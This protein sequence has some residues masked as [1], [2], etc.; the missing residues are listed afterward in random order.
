M[1]QKNQVLLAFSGG[2]DTTYCLVYLQ[3][4]GYQVTTATI[5]TGGFSAEELGDIEQKAKDLGA[6]KHVTIDG[7]PTIWEDAAYIIKGEYL[8]GGSYPSV[9]APERNAIVPE[10]VRLAEEEGIT[11]F[12]HGATGAGGD[13]VRFDVGL[14]ALLPEAK[15]LAPIREQSL[16]REQS[17]AYLQ[18]KGVAVSSAQKNYSLNVGL[19]GTTIGGVETLDTKQPLPDSA[20]P[21]VVPLSDT[22]DTPVSLALGFEAG[23][24]IALDGKALSGVEILAQLN[25]LGAVHGY[26]RGYHTGTSLLGVPARLGFEA[27]GLLLL[28]QAHRE[29]SKVIST[30]PERQLLLSLGGHWGDFMHQGKFYHPVMPAYQ[31]ALDVLNARLAG[32]VRMTLFKGQAMVESIDAPASRFAAAGQVKYGEEIDLDGKA[33]AEVCRMFDLEGVMASQSLQSLNQK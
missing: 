30:Q 11:T 18:E 20:F 6:V 2:L 22:P 3:E 27:P 15:V 21:S 9:V 25:K 28:L 7:R 29:L 8:R 14:S 23:L 5:D 19:L 31:A 1:G 10:L 33:M 12:A 16:S 24:P 13:Q 17:F 26:G 4:Q 32:E